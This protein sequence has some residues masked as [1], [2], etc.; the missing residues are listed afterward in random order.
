MKHRYSIILIL[1]LLISSASLYGQSKE[2]KF[3]SSFSKVKQVPTERLIARAKS[4]KDKDPEAAITLLEQVINQ[5]RKGDWQ[6]QGEAYILLGD[7]YVDINQIE[8]AKERYELALNTFSSYKRYNERIPIYIRLGQMAL[9]NKDS[10]EAERNFKLCLKYSADDKYSVRCEEGLVDL[11]LLNGDPDEGLNLINSIE[12]NFELDSLSNARLDARRAQN[13]IQQNDYSNASVSFLN[14]VQNLPKRENLSPEEYAPIEKAKN[15][16]LSYNLSSNI[17]KI[18]LSKTNI[19]LNSQTQQSSNLLVQE[20]LKI[21]SLYKAENNI[22]EAS[23]FIEKSK[24]IIDSNTDVSNIANVYKKSYE[25]NRQVG[26]MDNALADL[27]KYIEAKEKEIDNLQSELNQ[28]IRIVKGQQKIDIKS[29]EYDIDE[30]DKALLE[31]QLNIQKI[32]IGLLSILLIASLIFFYFLQ[33]NVKA[34]RKA[35]QLLYIKS[36]RTQMNP[37]FIFNA[38]NSVNNFIAKN[39]EKAANK[40][41]SDFSKLMRKVLDYSEKDF[42]DLDEELELNEL[43]LK[44]EHFRFRDQ[45]EYTFNN[46]IEEDKTDIQIPP[47]LI[48]PFIENAVWH[49]L[50]YKEE[51]GVLNVAI[52]EEGANIIISIDDNGIGRTKSKALKTENQK[53]YKSTGLNNIAKRIALINEIYKKNYQIE[54]SNLNE[55]E[56]ETGTAVRIKIPII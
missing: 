42:I 3:K 30:K 36:L 54:V 38:L 21:A 6:Y 52:K 10:D 15:D 56:E 37:H 31:S 44:L 25:I 9:D 43:Y 45:F 28:Q 55:E 35:N 27:E 51:K 41:L 22:I 53:K 4:L 47:M 20:N 24:D 33:K 46:Q 12:V 16:L 50:R 49:G 39:D 23:K 8:L 14:S 34:K 40:F 26:K 18:E 5:S 17:D 11:A 48:Q 19:E 13:Y 29:K 32:A 1:I 7:I 2:K